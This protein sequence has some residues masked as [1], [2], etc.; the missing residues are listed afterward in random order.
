MAVHLA[1][2]LLELTGWDNR[3]GGTARV[4][5]TLAAIH[6]LRTV[7]TPRRARVRAIL[8]ASS[9]SRREL[10]ALL[11]RCGSL[12]YA[13]ARAADF[14]AHALQAL[15]DVPSCQARE[16]LMETVRFL[17]NRAV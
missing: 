9:E 15:E 6:L 13:R 7:E 4:R 3:R 8:K 2:E 12:Q 14:L 16:A 5:P 1:D 17:V 11:E 10:G